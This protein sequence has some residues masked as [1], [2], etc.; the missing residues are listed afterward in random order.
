I[1]VRENIVR[2]IEHGEDHVTASHKGTDEI[3][4]AVTAT[5]FS[6]VAVFV[7]VGFM[8]GLGGQWFRPF[9]L[10]IPSPL[11]VSLFVSF[12]LDPMLSAYWP[13]PETEAH[14][15]RNPISRALDRFNKWF[16][17]QA[18]RYTGLIAWALDHR[19]SMIGIAAA[20]FFLAIFLQVRFGGF[21]F[22]PSSDRSELTVAIES[23][24]GASLDYTRLKTEEVE[25]IVRERPEVL[26]TYTTIGSSNGS[27]AVD[28]GNVY[29]KLKPKRDRAASQDQIGAA[30]RP[31]LARLGGVTAYVYT[32]G[33]GGNQKQIQVQV[34]GDDE[35]A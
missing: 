12:A 18:D 23:P 13:D 19:W 35:A 28:V 11:L 7:P 29:I 27:A 31:K 17:H 2:H 10:T 15:R 20:T 5:T 22:A 25:R 32:A 4:L 33:L 26:Y 16:D 30:L 3:G 9:A 14:E 21:G 34:R 24:A 1:V 8:G 6:I